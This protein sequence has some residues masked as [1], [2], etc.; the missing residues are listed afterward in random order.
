MRMSFCK[1]EN[2]T[3]TGESGL[4]CVMLTFRIGMHGLELGI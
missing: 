3:L 4:A 2:A 1:T